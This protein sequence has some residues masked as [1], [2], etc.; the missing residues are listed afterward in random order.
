MRISHPLSKSMWIGV[1]NTMP[2]YYR[3]TKRERDRETEIER[4]GESARERERACWII[5]NKICAK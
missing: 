1:F 3:E 4:E 2:E 5:S